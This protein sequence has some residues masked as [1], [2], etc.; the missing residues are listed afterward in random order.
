VRDP[1][2]QRLERAIPGPAKSR[3]D[4]TIGQVEAD[5]TGS[6]VAETIYT[7]NSTNLRLIDT[8]TGIVRSVGSGSVQHVAF[9][10]AH[11][12]IQ[13][14][15]AR[16]EVWNAAGTTLQRSLQQDSSYLPNAAA[17]TTAPT[18]RSSSPIWP[19]AMPWDP[20]LCLPPIRNSRRGSLQAQTGGTWLQ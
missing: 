2:T 6:F 4:S 14:R 16:F 12:L 19:R 7:P 20:L 9:S 8:N 10:G 15:S 3:N 11:L 5:P 13:R 17:V 1:A 18:A